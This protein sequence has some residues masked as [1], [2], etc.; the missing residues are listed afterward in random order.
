M[1]KI[2]RFILLTICLFT[3]SFAENVQSTNISISHSEDEIYQNWILVNEQANNIKVNDLPVYDNLS[4]SFYSLYIATKNEIY[5]RFSLYEATTSKREEIIARLS[6]FELASVQDLVSLLRNGEADSTKYHTRPYTFEDIYLFLDFD[7]PSE[8]KNNAEELLNFW[9]GKLPEYYRDSYIKGNFVTHSLIL[10]YFQLADYQKVIEVSRYLQNSNPFPNSTFSLHLFLNLS[11]SFRIN[12]YYLEALNIYKNILIPIALSLDNLQRYLEIRMDYALTQLR[13]GNVNIALDEYQYV[14]SN[15][16]KLLDTRYR[17][18]LFNNLA[19]CYLN[20][21]RFDQYVDFQLNAFQIANHEDNVGQQIIILRNLYI[22]YRRQNETDLA[23]NYLDQALQIARENNL[24]TD[25]ATI[26]LSFGIYKRSIENKPLISLSYFYDSLNLAKSYSN[27]QQIFNSYFEIA[28]TYLI[29]NDYDKAEDYIHNIIDLSLSR[30]DRRSYILSNIILANSYI[31]SGRIDEASSILSQF[32][33]QDL[34]QL[35]FNFRVLA[36]NISMQIQI[37]EGNYQAATIESTEMITEIIDWLRESSNQETGHMRMDDEFSEAFRLHLNLLQRVNMPQDALISI[38]E[39]RN[40]TRSGFYN[41]PLLKSQLLS[42]EELIL[43]YNLSTRIRQ[44]RS[45][46]VNASD[47]QKIYLSNELLA[48]TSE[49]NN[50]LNQ[51]IPQHSE[52]SY[53]S[54]LRT[55]RRQLR[56]DQMVLYVTVFDSQIFRFAITRSNIDMKVYPKDDFYIDLINSAVSSLGYGQTSLN[57]LHDIYSTFFDEI[58]PKRIRHIYFIP[59]GPFYRLPLEILPVTPPKSDTSYG[60]VSYFVEK[61]SV[62]YANSLSEIVRDRRA[63][64]NDFDYEIAGFGIRNFTSAGH[65]DLMDLPSGPVEITKSAE[66]LNRF[67]RKKVFLESESTAANFREIAGKSRI[68]HIATH[69]RVNNDNPLFSS[70]YMYNG[71]SGS[72]SD[73]N[74]SDNPGGI[75]H[76]YELFDLNLNADLIFLSSCESGSGGYLQGTGILGFSRAFSYA[77]ARSLTMNL[78]PIRDQTAAEIA[79]RFYEGL[80]MGK[81]KAEALRTAQISYLN[82]NNSDPYLWGA[83]VHYGDIDPIIIDKDNYQ[84]AFFITI[85]FII[86][87][88]LLYKFNK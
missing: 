42:E 7:I 78:W 30:N 14:Y 86:G 83:F 36:H 53:Q 56:S 34:G 81:S 18:A 48:A 16:E 52:T 87:S 4:E 84:L 45:Q 85:F 71:E 1:L 24:T 3:L 27:Y 26:L 67:S 40:I 39:L 10:G 72:H 29:L 68:L 2:R 32:N 63:H 88:I 20:T 13:I 60:S 75:I 47:E 54:A 55:L 73:K 25:I 9:L 66:A 43:D 77:G 21:G 50:L 11:Y 33:A 57:S 80:N 23:L 37:M 65:P 49:R 58:I 8:L 38:G 5:L 51:A 79:I 76:A 69:S 17:A 28:Q 15:I 6:H 64:S 22:F 44:L 19:I 74:G 46:Y 59:D 70:F 82:H 35:V 41:N 61:F 62:S 12:G 31:K